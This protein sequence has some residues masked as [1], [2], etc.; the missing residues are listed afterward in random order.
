MVIEREEIPRLVAPLAGAW[1]ETALR[2]IRRREKV[3]APLAGAWIETGL[4]RISATLPFVA[5]LAGA[6]IETAAPNERLIPHKRRA[7]RGRVD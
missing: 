4:P 2:D 7:P 6:W 5:P 3:V 1:I